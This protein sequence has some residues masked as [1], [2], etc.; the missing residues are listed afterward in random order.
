M[1]ELFKKHVVGAFQNIRSRDATFSKT[2][3]VIFENILNEKA[4]NFVM[5]TLSVIILILVQYF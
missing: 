1:F 2:V 5:W 4:L 3:N